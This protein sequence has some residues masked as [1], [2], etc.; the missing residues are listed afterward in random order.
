MN[1]TDYPTMDLLA[2]AFTMLCHNSAQHYN[3]MSDQ[4]DGCDWD[5]LQLQ[6]ANH[7]RPWD[8][9]PVVERCEFAIKYHEKTCTMSHL[10]RCSWQY[11]ISEN[12][13]NWKGHSHRNYLDCAEVA[14]N[15]GMRFRGNSAG[16]SLPN[17]TD[18]RAASAPP[19]SSCSTAEIKWGNKAGSW[20]EHPSGCA[21]GA[22]EQ[23]NED[24]R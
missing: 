14:Y 17:P 3:C 22:C 11:E 10:D 16:L 6:I 4:C 15:S 7:L 12:V 23:P 2:A 18:Q 20:P 13:H 24:E 21:C 5:A 19:E 8:A 1:V 9:L